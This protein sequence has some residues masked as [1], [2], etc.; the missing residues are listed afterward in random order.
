MAVL[1]CRLHEL[2]H[3]GHHFLWHCERS[4]FCIQPSD[5]VALDFDLPQL[6]LWLARCLFDVFGAGVI[7]QTRGSGS[8]AG[9]SFGLDYYFVYIDGLINV[10]D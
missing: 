3:F 9:K 5:V 4:D 10:D 2:P 8:F 1:I 7:D 6:R